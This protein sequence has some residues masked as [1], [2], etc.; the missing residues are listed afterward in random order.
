MGPTV[1]LFVDVE[2]IARTLFSVLCL[3]YVVVVYLVISTL[4]F[5]GTCGYSFVELYAI[6]CPPHLVSTLPTNTCNLRHLSHR[7]LWTAYHWS[8]VHFRLSNDLLPLT[9]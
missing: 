2:A 4:A 7:Y 1:V 5:I 3:I 6:L 8:G 9:G